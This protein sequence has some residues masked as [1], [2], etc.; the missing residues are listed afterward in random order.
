MQIEV[1]SSAIEKIERG[2]AIGRL[3]ESARLARHQLVRIG[4]GGLVCAKIAGM[5][6]M[7]NRD[8]VNH[9][10]LEPKSWVTV[11]IG[12]PQIQRIPAGDRARF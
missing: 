6:M 9:P 8:A 2:G 10:N 11:R 1:L 4:G 7:Q 12:P 5:K 3:G